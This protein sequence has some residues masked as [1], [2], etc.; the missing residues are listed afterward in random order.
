MGKKT[1]ADLSTVRVRQSLKPHPNGHPYRQ[2]IRPGCFVGYRPQPDGAAGLW[3]AR[4]YDEEARLYR[5]K[6]L[7]SFAEKPAS[8]R[9]AVAK[10]AAEAFAATIEA[11][12]APA[13]EVLTTADACRE[14][15]KV[16]P[17]AEG[18]F[19]RHVYEEPIGKIALGKLRRRHLKDWRARLAARPAL[20]SRRKKGE[21]LTRPRA[22][23]SINRDMAMLRAALRKVLPP[24][25]PNTEAAWQEALTAIKNADGRRTLYLDREQRRAL[26]AKTSALAEPFVRALCLLPLRPGAL[27]A[28]SVRDFD[29]RTGELTI[30]KDKAGHA[31]RII[32]PPAAAKLLT[33]QSKDKL[34][35]AQL[36]AREAG[37]PWDRHTWK[38]PI[39]EAAAA[40]KLPAETTA[41]TLRHSTITDLVTGGLPLLTV[42]QVSGTSA[43]MIEKHYGHLV[44]EAARKALAKL[45]I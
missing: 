44:G 23:A 17:E 18:R 28:L 14:Y 45:T 11:G 27:A 22:P 38:T 30:G 4:A 25:Q 6:A 13:V 3:S 31:R 12:G 29:R 21:R 42:A 20:V 8:E 5:D 41:Y 1:S 24:G 39:R 37:A 7:G 19:K 32:I 16:N 33:E 9:F 43:A 36:F 26:L 40:A 10:A 35:T 15:A 2:R 34:P